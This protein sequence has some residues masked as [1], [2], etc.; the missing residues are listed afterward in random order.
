MVARMVT[1][2]APF[3]DAERRGVYRAIHERRDV[4]SRFVP[5]PVPD[6]VLSRIL[7]AAHH[8]PS[9]GLMQPWEFIVIADAGI[10]RD[11]RAQFD[12]ANRRAA[13]AYA[14]ER[15]DLYDSL[16]LEAIVDSAVNVCV[17]CDPT[18]VRGHGL[19][20]QTMPETAM[21]S[22]VCAIQNCWL[23]AR[24]EGVGVGWISILDVDALRTTLAIPPHVSIVG[25]LC[26]GYVSAFD[27]QPELATR[28]WEHRVPLAGTLH[29][30]RYGGLDSERAQA[31]ARL[32]EPAAEGAR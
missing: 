4:R 22:A 31:L 8:A 12:A 6:E 11:V 18:V 27:A 7:D 26:L 10:R 24:A 14:G 9:V 32:S 20:R 29:F 1:P 15:R 30:D 2:L 13:A 25:Y 23:A 28:G 19:G 5:Q 21:Y 17:T 3:T 16:K